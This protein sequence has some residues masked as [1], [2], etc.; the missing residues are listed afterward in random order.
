MR[1]L[2]AQG[3]VV[4]VGSIPIEQ[5]FTSVLGEVMIVD[6]QEIQVF[7]Y[8]DVTAATAVASAIYYGNSP[9][10]E[11][12]MLTNDDAHLYQIGNVL[13]LY[14]GSEPAITRLLVKTFGEREIG[15]H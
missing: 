3:A 4:G 15:I 6:N 9:G 12:L 10:W 11:Q 5:P 14:T 13:L 2:Q 8:A 1:S 7:E